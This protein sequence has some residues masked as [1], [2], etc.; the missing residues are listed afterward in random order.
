MKKYYHTYTRGLENDVIFRSTDDYVVGM[1]YVPVALH[2]KDISLLAFTLMSNHFH[3]IVWS[4][5]QH[6]VDL[7]NA[8]KNLISRYIYSK[9]RTRELLRKVSTGISAING[10]EE[11]LK[12][13]IAYVLNNPA[14][15]GINCFALSYEWGSGKC[16]F[17]G[18]NHHPS[19]VPLGSHTARDQRRIL[20]THVKL[21]QDYQITPAGYI[22][23]TSYIDWKSVEQLYHKATSM[24]Y[25]L[26]MSRKNMTR[27]R[28]SLCFT[29][30]LL[31]N[32]V[33]QMLEKN[34][35]GLAVS[36][37]SLESVSTLVKDLNR[38]LNSS[39]KQIAR[40]LGLPVQNIVDILK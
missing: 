10:G 14:E 39:A 40:V 28:Y 31:L 5:E 38:R 9:Y 13:K 1:N 2:D 12:E 24:Q 23:P 16:Y 34:F 33:S 8:Y 21:P 15:A 7:I 19:N 6:A 32:I 18:M 36:E 30:D 29:D 27:S 26:N 17:T 35:G 25:H 37:L 4:T 22:D 20:R 11:G 3:F